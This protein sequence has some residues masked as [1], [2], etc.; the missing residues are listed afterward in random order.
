MAA[1][2]NE[3]DADGWRPIIGGGEGAPCKRVWLFV[4]YWVP[5]PES[6]WRSGLT[7]TH[8]AARR[9]AGGRHDHVSGDRAA[10]SANQARRGGLMLYGERARDWRFLPA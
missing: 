2:A 8:S 4:L 3:L 9:C 6:D 10:Q 7:S 5:V 1:S